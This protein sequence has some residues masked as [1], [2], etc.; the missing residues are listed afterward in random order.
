MITEKD[1]RPIALEFAGFWRRLGAFII[2]LTVM[3]AAAS[4]LTPFRW[5]GFG[6]F[7]DLSNLIE[8]PILSLPFVAI[9]NPISVILSCVYFVALWAW[10]DQ[11]LGMMVLNIRLIRPDGT[12]VDTGHSITRLFGSIIAAAPFFIG[13]IW[14]AFD[15]RKQGWHDKLAATYVVKIPKLP[16]AET[17]SPPVAGG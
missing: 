11:T 1:R 16:D 4:F 14:I 17:A 12:N 3:G 6:N 8:V 15:E 9:A 2:D 10:R 7:F 13:L 5:F